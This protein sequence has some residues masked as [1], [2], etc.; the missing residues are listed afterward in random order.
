MLVTSTALVGVTMKGIIITDM[1]AVHTVIA[2]HIMHTWF[3]E[4]G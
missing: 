2:L 3:K 1:N 4:N